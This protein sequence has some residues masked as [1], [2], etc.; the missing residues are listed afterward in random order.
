MWWESQSVNFS[1]VVSFF[2]PWAVLPPFISGPACRGCG[3]LN[4]GTRK[5][6][7]SFKQQL[8][9]NSVF[10]GSAAGNLK[11]CVMLEWRSHKH[12]AS[13]WSRSTTSCT[14]LCPLLC[15][16]NEFRGTNS[17]VV[18]KWC[19]TTVTLYS[20]QHLQK[21]QTTAECGSKWGLLLKFLM[22]ATTLQQPTKGPS[23]VTQ[24]ILNMLIR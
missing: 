19:A 13:C 5:Y 18:S 1:P 2:S 21:P 22:S 23:T 10:H 12:R 17:R 4:W 11:F 6:Y 8:A 15:Q 20:T 7:K 24:L 9:I 14:H 3:A 16:A